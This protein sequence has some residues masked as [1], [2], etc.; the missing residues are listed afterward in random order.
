MPVNSI[1][2]RVAS[3]YIM[4]QHFLWSLHLTYIGTELMGT[5]PPTGSTK[6]VKVMVA[7]L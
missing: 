1:A 4:A 2:I 3:M 6:T 5:P 7:S